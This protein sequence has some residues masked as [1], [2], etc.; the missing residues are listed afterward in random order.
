MKKKL[1]YVTGSRA[2]YGI[3]KR[4]L[5]KIVA[6]GSIEL[7]IVATGMHCDPKYGN[8][9]L[10]I[11]EDGFKIDKLI[12]IN[13]DSST[14]SAV[15]STMS[16]CQEIFGVFFENNQYDAVMILG[17]RYEMLPI[18]I[19]AAMH[20]IPIIHLHG[21]EQTLGNYDEFIRHCI[22]KMSHLHL[23]STE[24]YRRRVIQLGEEPSSVVNIGALGAENALSLPILDKNELE[25]KYGLSLD[26]YFVVAFHPETL[27][28][29]SV[30]QQ[31]TEI[32][33]ALE[34]AHKNHQ[35]SYIF[36]GSN[37]DTNSDIITKHLVSFCE[38]FNFKY[39]VS[40]PTQD[41]LGLCKYSC[42]LIGNSSSGLIEVP[43]LGIPTINIGDRQAG[44][45]RGETVIDVKCNCKDLA[46]SIDEI[47]LR[48]NKIYLSYN[49]PYYKKN[50][51]EIALSTINSFMSGIKENM[52]AIKQFYD[53][54]L[55]ND[56]IKP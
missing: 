27:T 46:S 7:S 1:L 32:T 38:R 33:T 26:N 41:Y 11:I 37:S 39:L 47:V 16:R 22:T 42:G 5:Q 30:Y 31:I 2:E 25:I 14:N 28:S 43:S 48:D 51:A 6:N 49:N 13:I 29:Q 34:L 54:P 36:I 15:I 50:S 23:V 52:P 40:I 21:G 17:D 4:L 9:Y 3:M 10:N 24:C 45:I 20:G 19:A 56:Q 44:R 35:C 55:Y 18:A 12:D 8:T 53:L